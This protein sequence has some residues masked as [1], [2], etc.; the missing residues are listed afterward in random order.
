[1]HSKKKDISRLVQ[2]FCLSHSAT[3]RQETIR[4]FA[5]NCPLPNCRV[6]ARLHFQLHSGTIV[7]QTA[8]QL[9][10]LSTYN[11]RNRMWQ[12]AFLSC[13]QQRLKKYKCGSA[14]LKGLAS[15]L[16]YLSRDLS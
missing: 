6:E 4:S 9:Q 2:F 14:D 1:M 13:R 8:S 10:N 7:Y 15:M 16:L 3:F 5:M 12:R 11:C